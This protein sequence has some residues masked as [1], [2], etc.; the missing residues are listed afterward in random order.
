MSDSNPFGDAMDDAESNQEREESSAAER[1]FDADRYLN[2]LGAGPKD[3]TIG[4]AVDEPTHRFYQEL[5]DAQ[6]VD[7]DVADSMREHLQ[8]LARRHPDVFERAMRKMEID[9]EY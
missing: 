9:R 1:E 5:A 3:K 4:F 8:K 2:E 7:V 6:D